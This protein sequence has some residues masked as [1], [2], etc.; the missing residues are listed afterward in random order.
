MILGRFMGGSGGDSSS[1]GRLSEV[2][3]EWASPP[4]TTTTKEEKDPNK[5]AVDGG[6]EQADAATSTTDYVPIT[7]TSTAA[8]SSAPSQ[9]QA[10]KEDKNDNNNDNESPPPSTKI[11]TESSDIY[12]SYLSMLYPKDSTSARRGYVPTSPIAPSDNSNDADEG[13]SELFE[14]DGSFSSQY[15]ISF[16]CRVI[17][18]SLPSTHLHPGVYVLKRSPATLNNKCGG[19]QVRERFFKIVVSPTNHRLC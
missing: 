16:K 6:D 14:I 19:Q 3:S 8:P 10:P 15:T 7:P 18:G 5:M 13:K 11:S 17:S 1:T 2:K 12:S 4:P 9:A